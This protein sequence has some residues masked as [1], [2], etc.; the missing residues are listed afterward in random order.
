MSF[1]DLMGSAKGP[2]LIGLLLAL[3][4]LVGF[5]T[6]FTLSFDQGGSSKK[7]I[8]AVIRENTNKI[9]EYQTKIEAGEAKL[10]TAPGLQDIARELSANIIKSKLITDRVKLRESEISEITSE[11][12]EIHPEWEDYKNE[13]RTYV[14]SKAKGDKI[15]EL[16]ALD[17]T[18]YINVEIRKVTAIGIEIRH[19]DGFKRIPFRELPLKMQDHFQFDEEQML[20]ENKREKEVRQKHNK[21][22][23]A[24]HEAAAEEAEKQRMIKAEEDRKKT[25]ELISRGKARVTQIEGEIVQIQSDIESAERAADAA[26][27]SGKRHLNKSNQYRGDLA[28]KRT[29]LLNVQ[30]EIARLESSL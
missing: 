4:V 25:I 7:S 26:R 30:R 28:I 14:R 24:A 21:Q 3:I 29:E 15:A 13:Y 22:V 12:E 11:I 9:A 1:S 17:G 16:K 8:E 6:L 23:N 2:G 20:A 10:A 5:G 18:T 19:R 27:A